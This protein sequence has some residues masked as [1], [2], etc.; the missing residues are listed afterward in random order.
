MHNIF[1]IM[2]TRQNNSLDTCLV[3]EHHPWRKLTL[4][5]ERMA[6]ALGPPFLIKQGTSLEIGHSS[7]R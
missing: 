2:H 1:V 7:L 4:H 3:K 6:Q 5:L